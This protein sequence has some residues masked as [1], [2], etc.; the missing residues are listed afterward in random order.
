MPEATFTYDTFGRRTSKTDINGNTTTYLYDGDNPIQETTGSTVRTLLT[1]LG[2][3]ERYARDDAG[4]GNREYFLTDALGSTL[5][6]TDGTG[7][8]QQTYAYE[9]YGEVAATGSSDNPYQYTGREND[10][11]SL[12]TGLYYYR[13]RYYSPTLKRFIAEDPMGLAAG[14]NEYAYVN[15]SPT[16]WRDPSGR[17]SVINCGLGSQSDCPNIPASYWLPEPEEIKRFRECVAGKVRKALMYQAF[18]MGKKIVVGGVIV[19]FVPPPWDLIAASAYINNEERIEAAEMGHTLWDI[20]TA[21]RECTC[22]E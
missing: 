17:Q 16:N 13:A 9:P 6:L 10:D 8:V 1:G 21:D 19:L 5:A 12:G 7:T 2:I 11:Q 20:Y 22:G 4:I 3:D 18:G 15:G 14:L